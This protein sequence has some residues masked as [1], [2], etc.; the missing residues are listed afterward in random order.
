MK[1]TVYA[2]VIV[3]C[4]ILAGIIF[5]VTKSG[6]TGGVE[7]L[8]RGEMYLVKCNNEA[9]GATYEIDRVDYYKAVDQKARANPMS[10]Q[11]PA[12]V[13]QKCGKESVFRAV[14]CEKCGNV[15]FW[16]NPSDFNDRCPKCGYSAEE[17]K[18]K[19]RLAG[20]GNQ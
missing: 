9:C 5:L 10:L 17:A 14:K 12:L 20:E 3:G 13:C 6:G 19:A 8:P 4:L 1:N 15:F 16:G 11:T 18:R 7:D 2:I